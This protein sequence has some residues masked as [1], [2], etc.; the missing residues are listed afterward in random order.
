PN[1]VALGL[2]GAGLGFG[3]IAGPHSALLT[4]VPAAGAFL[5]LGAVAS[6]PVLARRRRHTRRALAVLEGVREATAAISACDW[7]LLGAVGY[8]ALDNAALWAAFRAFGHSPSLGVLAMAY[9]LGGI[10]AALPLPA[11]L[12]G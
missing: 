3:W 7:K 2:A 1:A 6:L 5:V 11:G 8:Y 4:L 10:G 9:G 12:V